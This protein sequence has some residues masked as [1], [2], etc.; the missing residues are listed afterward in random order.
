MNGKGIDQERQTN[1]RRASH[2]PSSSS[3]SSSSPN[4][5]LRVTETGTASSYLPN[6]PLLFL[7]PSSSSSATSTFFWSS[8]PSRSRGNV[9]PLGTRYRAVSPRAI[10]K[11]RP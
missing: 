11:G 6:L 2:R 9:R 3:S 4:N 7:S 1:G 5:L 10:H 8:C